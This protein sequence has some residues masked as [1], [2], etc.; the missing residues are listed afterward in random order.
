[1][2]SPVRVRVP[3]LIFPGQEC[4]ETI[5][6]NLHTSKIVLLLVAIK[7][8]LSDLADSVLAGEHDKGSAAVAGQFLN[9]IIRAVGMELKIREDEELEQRIELLE[10]NAERRGES[11]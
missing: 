5:D 2:V 6:Q 11:L 9:Y 1:M 4:E 7:Q 8:R 3:P 10:A